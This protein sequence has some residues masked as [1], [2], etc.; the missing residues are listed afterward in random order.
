MVIIGWK[1]G[2]NSA[3]FQRMW[4]IAKSIAQKGYKIKYIFLMPNNGK[5]NKEHVPNLECVYL[6][7]KCNLNNKICT[8]IYSLF[9]LFRQIHKGSTIIYYT[10][11]P[12]L[13]VIRLI[14]RIKLILE[15]NEYPPFIAKAN[16]FN[17]VLFPLYLDTA[18]KAYKIFV[19]SK[20]L[21][22]YFIE[23]NVDA[24]N[25][26]ILNMTVDSHR[27]TKINKQG[28]EKYIAYCGTMSCYKDGV[29][30]LIEAFANVVNKIPNIKLYLLG[31]TPYEKDRIKFESLINKHNLSSK[32]YMP[33]AVP[34]E[35]IPQYLINAEV[36]ALARPNNIQATY[37]FPTKLG[38]Y[39]LTG[40]P[41]VVT[42]V[43]ELEDFLTDKISCVFAEPNSVEDFTDKLLWVLNNGN[44]GKE[45][46][47]NGKK[48]AF[49][50]FNSD[51]ESLKI[52]NVL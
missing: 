26:D 18:R 4:G 48:I 7:E 52:I 12:T 8:I 39:L 10:F 34:A 38:E 35:E 46:G 41:V 40:N 44:I 1:F 22:D 23:Q 45:I 14:P 13:F 49:K 6:G 5:I 17:R 51:N 21:K 24:K 2:D 3:E 15:V 42:R 30:I 11:L 37:G 47:N 16:I 28:S 31:K 50:Y 20:K 19:I 33:G 9:C 29:D 43:G 32:I 25:I 36:L 27:F